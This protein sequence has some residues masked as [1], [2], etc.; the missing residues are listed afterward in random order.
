MSGNG[1]PILFVYG[2]LPA[3]RGM[4]RR[5]LR[6]V[7]AVLAVVSLVVAAAL[8]YRAWRQTAVARELAITTPNG[9]EEARFVHIGG[10]DQYITIRG[11]DRA[12]PVILFVHGGPGDSM[13]PFAPLYR[14]W[15]RYFT[16]VQ[17]DQRGAG[18]TFGR[19]GMNEGPMTI[20]RFVR[21]G[22]EVTQYLRAH[23]R[24]EKIILVALSWGTVVGV[25]MIKR[26]PDLFAAYVGTGQVVAKAEKEIVLYGRLMRKLEAA[27]DTEGIRRL[28]TVTPPYTSEAELQ[29]ER[30][31]SSRFDIPSERDI[32]KKMTPVVLFAPNYSLLDIRDF[33]EAPKTTREALYREQL[34][35]D[36]RK[37]GRDFAVPFFIFEGEADTITPPDIAKA[38]FDSVRAPSKAFVVFRNAGHVAI[39][40][41]PDAFLRELL[42]R[43]R[44]LAR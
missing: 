14:P 11:D 27:H 7:I 31:V 4:G 22:L 8:S 18:K 10:I 39:L 13:V 9:I 40:A 26:Q 42:V 15:E 30:E 41:M 38:Y 32:Q 19:S 25:E 20:E 33:L 35:Y 2:L 29:V 3:G 16:I 34:S 28:K 36:A 17:W 21:D 44:P 5:F 24:K 37:L 23:L 6:G 1:R 12:N 43:V